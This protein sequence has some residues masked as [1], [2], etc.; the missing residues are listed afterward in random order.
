[1]NY[2]IVIPR[3]E[4]TS[5]YTRQ[6]VLHL[7]SH[8]QIP[9]RCAPRDDKKD[10]CAPRDDKKDCCA[11]RDDNWLAADHLLCQRFRLDQTADVEVAEI[12]VLRARL[13]EAHLGDELLEVHR[14]LGEE[15]HAPLPP[16]ESDRAGD[17][18]RSSPRVAPAREAVT[19]HQLAPL[20]KR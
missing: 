20:R 18:L 10:W 3:S 17:D 19:V 12:G 7:A 1:M 16:I 5:G 9:R 14:I 6:R 13:V 2:P 11:S 8:V 15:R 4:A